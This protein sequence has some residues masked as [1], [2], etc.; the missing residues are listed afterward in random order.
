VGER[1]WEGNGARAVAPEKRI[2]GGKEVGTIRHEGHLE[3]LGVVGKRD[4]GRGCDRGKDAAHALRG[5]IRKLKG[6]GV[7]GA[8]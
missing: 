6:K 2:G 7:E 1:E 3:G 5:F 8:G 4:G